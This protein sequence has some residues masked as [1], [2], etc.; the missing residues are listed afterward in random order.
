M[1]LT[2]IRSNQRAIYDNDG[3][4]TQEVEL[5]FLLLDNNYK[6]SL[7]QSII[8]DPIIKTIRFNVSFE[9]LDQVIKTLKEIKEQNSLIE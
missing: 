7:D 8:K 1:Y 6:L 3:S 4:L 5:I 2:Q 9:Q